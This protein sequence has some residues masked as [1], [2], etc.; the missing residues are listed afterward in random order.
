M[1]LWKS[2]RAYMTPTHENS[3][4]PHMLRRGSLVFFMA[5]A[6]MTEGFLAASLVARQSD[7]TFLS[8]VVSATAGSTPAVFNKEFMEAFNE[9]LPVT[10]WTLGLI[11]GLLMSVVSLAFFLHIE[12]QSGEML[13]GG[14]VVAA[15]A[16]LCLAAN[17]T[18]L[19]PSP[20]AATPAT[21]GAAL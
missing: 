12:V 6:L 1:R 9:P 16:L 18:F 14:L 4:R 5:L 8:S 15:L 11:A 2:V 7:S 21:V 13:L 20:P 10:D 17:V 3:Y 19:S